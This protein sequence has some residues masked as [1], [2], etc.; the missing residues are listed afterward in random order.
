MHLGMIPQ[1]KVLSLTDDFECSHRSQV[2]LSH[3]YLHPQKKII[4]S[5]LKNAQIPQA[6]TSLSKAL[7]IFSAAFIFTL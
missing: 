1:K 4:N 5:F 2:Y 3:F 7:A 6:R